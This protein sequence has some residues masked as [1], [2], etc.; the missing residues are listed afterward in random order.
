M[1]TVSFGIDYYAFNSNSKL[2]VILDRFARLSASGANPRECFVHH[3]TTRYGYEYVAVGP[4]G[5]YVYYFESD[6]RKLVHVPGRACSA[7]QCEGLAEIFSSD[8]DQSPKRIDLAWTGICGPNYK[9]LDVKW[10]YETCRD[11]PWEVRTR[12][13]IIPNPNLPSDKRTQSLQFYENARGRTC[14]VGSRTS[15]RFIRFY[16]MRGPTRLEL[17]LKGD[18]AISAVECFAGKSAGSISATSLG[19]L[20][21]F[22]DFVDPAGYDRN[23]NKHKNLWPCQLWWLVF[24]QDC[25]KRRI[26]REIPGVNADEKLLWLKNAAIPTINAIVSHQNGD[27]SWLLDMLGGELNSNGKKLLATTPRS[28]AAKLPATMKT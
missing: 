9:P 23:V 5:I 14:Y 24:C 28:W 19:L 18:R 1:E 7:L 2:D 22:L 12:A 4:H 25:E 13:N 17:E 6:K 3:P 8:M 15:E 21:D 10:V 27:V 20:R 26:S 11:R 16:D